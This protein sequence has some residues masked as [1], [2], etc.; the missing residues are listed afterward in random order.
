M[1]AHKKKNVPI[2]EQ[3]KALRKLVLETPIEEI[4]PNKNKKAAEAL[5]R[6]GLNKK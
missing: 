4:L 5:K 2:E 3:K 6:A 1:A